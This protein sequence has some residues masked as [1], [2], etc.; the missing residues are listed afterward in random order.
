MPGTRKPEHGSRISARWRIVG[1][2]VLTTAVILLAVMVTMRSVLLGQVDTRANH[3]IVQEVDEFAT[4]AAEGVDPNTA[5]PFTS[6]T[7]MM[8]RYLARQTPATG[9]TLIAVTSTDVSF[10]DNAARDAGEILAGDRDRL[11][12]ILTHPEESGIASTPQGELR[13]GRT[14]ARVGD[15]SGTLIV[16]AFTEAAREQVDRHTLVL[17]GVAT[18]GLLLTAGMAWLAA[19]QIL[20]PIRDVREVADRVDALDLSA[21]VPVQGRDDIA[22]LAVTFNEML[23]R[24]ERAH[25]SQRHFVREVQHHLTGPRARIEQH[26][27]TLAEGSSDEQTFGAAIRGVRREMDVM[28]STLADLELLARSDRSD[29]LSTRPVD[30]R[31]LARGVYENAA[32]LAPD[33]SWALTGS[34]TGTAVIDPD[35]VSDAMT[36]LVR[37]AYEHTD[38]GASI[39]VGSDLLDDG[40]APVV[41]LWVGNDGPRLDQE[42]ARNLFER[43]RPEPGDSDGSST[44][45]MG[46]GL[47]VVRAVADAH[48][49]SAWVESGEAV[50]TRFGLDLPARAPAPAHGAQEHVEE[51]T[52]AL[53]HEQ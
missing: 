10:S 18:G 19:G 15:Q 34:A 5:R 28:A 25:G 33:R 13:W 36:Q 2:I 17:L 52:S 12:E 22:R 46:L 45:G 51:L 42:Q 50:G 38:S 26:L 4:F 21:R 7:A 32:A 40:S 44:E 6:A 35:R 37:N 27:R 53:R 30:V 48:G 3:D 23:D 9:E 29:F 31:E 41:R 43:F 49:G 11:H 39:R 8:E 16:G 14:S 47:A 1:W 24:V 20:R